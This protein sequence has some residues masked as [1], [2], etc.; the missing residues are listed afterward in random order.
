M[1]EY[2]HWQDEFSVGVSLIDAQHQKL[3]QVINT[4]LHSQE[5]GEPRAAVEQSLEEMIRY[6]EYHFYSEQLLL[7]P[8]PD[9]LAHLNQHWQLIKKTRRIQRDF[10]ADHLLPAEVSAFL[11]SWLKNH[12]LGTDQVY[13][14]YLRTHDLLAK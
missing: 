2:I 9:F 11:I 6:T 8:H 3:L 5:D 14:T 10:L 13:F 7:E 1:R 4:F 12:I